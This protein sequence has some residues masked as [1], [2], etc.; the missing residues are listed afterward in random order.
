[1]FNTFPQV[2]AALAARFE[3]SETEIGSLVS[4]YMGSFAV[5]A[6][7]APFWTPRV[8]WKATA[9]FSYIGIGV[10]VLRIMCATVVII[11][12]IRDGDGAGIRRYRLNVCSNVPGLGP[13]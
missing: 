8:P 4:A 10:G 12:V 3:L 6:L 9:V 5:V 1:M 2:L 11:R 7:L 13:K